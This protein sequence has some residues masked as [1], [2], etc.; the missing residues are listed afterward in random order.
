MKSTNS[1]KKFFSIT[2]KIILFY[3]LILLLS[4]ILTSISS[5]LIFQKLMDSQISIIDSNTNVIKSK[6]ENLYKKNVNVFELPDLKSNKESQ[7]SS[8]IILQAIE[9]S[10]PGYKFKIP[11]VEGTIEYVD[12]PKL[13]YDKKEMKY[14]FEITRELKFS[15][16]FPF[17]SLQLSIKLNYYQI[18]LRSLILG[19]VIATA[20]L[21]P[22]III[23][24]NTIIQ[25]I[26]KLTKGAKSIA[27][28][29]LGIQVKYNSS[30]ELGELSE[31]FN[32]MS[33][34]LIKIKKIRDD[35]LATISHEI[36]SPLA[37]IKGYTELLSDLKLK[38]NEQKEYFDA[39]LDEVETLNNMT[40]EIIEISRLELNKERF[41]KEDIDLNIF[42]SQFKEY[43]EVQKKL[44]N[45]DY[46]I[47]C[48]DNLVC[49]L[50][51]DKFKRV[52][53]NIIQNSIKAKA[54]N[55][56]ITVK[57][58]NNMAL[59]IC[60][61][62]GIGIPDD[63]LEIVFEKFYRVDKSRD[64]NT[65]GFGLGLAICKAIIKEHKGDIFFVPSKNG[66]ELHIKLPLKENNNG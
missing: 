1:K 3:L 34:E 49:N 6:V 61:D 54:K 7:N 38:K 60:K 9:K 43:M 27:E 22:I 45:I 30:D 50:D 62:D 52:L 63:Q 4:V 17:K 42:F 58:D 46:N 66:A 26:I 10:F 56:L 25:P 14:Y 20:I 18:I 32:Y 48:E 35:L 57:K 12:I 29:N 19:T 39:I 15:E 11:T 23:F 64:R 51:L 53:Q 41:L 21:I 47:T 2:Q 24:S 40:A 16:N 28:G 31:S 5:Y 8:N 37:R 36:R 65:G 55:I 44:F 59:I 13:V 33:N